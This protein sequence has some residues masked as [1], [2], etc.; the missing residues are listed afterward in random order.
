MKF[1]EIFKKSALWAVPLTAIVWLV[2]YVSGF[3]KLTVVNLYSAYNPVSLISTAPAKSIAGFVTGYIPAASII[4]NYGFVLLYLGA[5]I[6]LFVGLFLMNLTG[7]SFKGRYGHFA[8]VILLGTVPLYILFVGLKWVPMA[9]WL[10]MA[11]WLVVVDFL[12]VYITSHISW[13]K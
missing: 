11:I 6:A 13:F 8:S 4:N 12:F 9:L 1:E 5:F 2:A 3:L 10:G 7:W